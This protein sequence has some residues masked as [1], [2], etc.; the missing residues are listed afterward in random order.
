[1]LYYEKLLRLEVFTTNDV[2]RLINSK[3]AAL[4]LL[5]RYMEKGIIRKIK[6]NLYTC[7]NLQNGE[8]AAN[9]F[10]IGSNINNT[11]YIS[12]HS[13][14][15]YYGF[16]NQVF[17]DIYVS[18]DNRFAT[19]GFEGI[20]YKHVR[21]NT[22]KGIV[23]SETNAKIK[24]T[25]LERTVIDCIKDIDLA[26]GAEEL[27]Q[28]LELVTSL[29]N[30]KFYAYLNEYDTQFLY[31]KAGFIFERYRESLNITDDLIN[32]CLDKVKDCVRYFDHATKEEKG[33]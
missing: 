17:Y 26:G 4:A 28:C 30:G 25:D 9:R 18:S 29:D 31:Q 23:V 7:V 16:T 10:M 3:R 33:Y 5:Q 19:F 20:T 21:S 12:H 14:F 1:M 24:V 15:E 8:S 22:E 32:Y 27:L 6:K 11:A 13:A 2:Y